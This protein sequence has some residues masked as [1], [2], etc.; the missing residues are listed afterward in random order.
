ML[1]QIK[2]KVERGRKLP[3][4]FKQYPPY[5]V[6][7]AKTPKGYASGS[8]GLL[9]LVEW[10]Y[11]LISFRKWRITGYATKG[12][13]SKMVNGMQKHGGF[14]LGSIGGAAAS[15]AQNCT[16][17]VE[18][19]EFDDLGMEATRKTEAENFQPSLLLTISE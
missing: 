1:I 14:Y 7:P 4:Y 5:Y 16:K 18:T 11:S 13:R 3:D 17:N 10:M 9:P 2:G 15:L 19:I 12:N 6:G 8:F